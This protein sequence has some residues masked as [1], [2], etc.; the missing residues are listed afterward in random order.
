LAET[1]STQLPSISIWARLP[2]AAAA[3]LIA[4][5]IARSSVC[6][7]HL[8]LIGYFFSAYRMHPL[9]AT[10]ESEVARASSNVP[11]QAVAAVCSQC[12]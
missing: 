4:I 12:P 1:L 6:R 3:L 10:G 8:R 5:A 7:V 9:R 2:A 11:M